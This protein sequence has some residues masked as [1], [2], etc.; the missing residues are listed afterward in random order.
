MAGFPLE[1]INGTFT[2]SGNSGAFDLTQFSGISVIGDVGANILALSLQTQGLD[3]NWYEAP[4][5][6]FF[7]GSGP[8]SESFI[9]TNFDAGRIFW[10]LNPAYTSTIDLSVFGIK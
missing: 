10:S 4:G 5:S 7:T 3:G 1:L 9:A 6:P 2:G 8:I